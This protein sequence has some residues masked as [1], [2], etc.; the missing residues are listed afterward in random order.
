MSSSLKRKFIGKD[1]S[2]IFSQSKLPRKKDQP[3]ITTNEPVACIHD[4]SYPEGY[5]TP[6]KPDDVQI[7][8]KVKKPAKEFSFELDPFQSEAIKCLD[9]GESV[10]VRLKFF[11]FWGF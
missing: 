8:S 5:V 9:S 10:M 4:V 2:E 7:T 3:I 6:C 11:M 1:E